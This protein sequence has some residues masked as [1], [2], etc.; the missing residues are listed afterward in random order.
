MSLNFVHDF[1][2]A[3]RKELMRLPQR[4]AKDKLQEPLLSLH[5]LTWDFFNIVILCALQILVAPGARHLVA[6]VFNFQENDRV[7]FD[8]R[9]KL[10]KSN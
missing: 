1:G 2:G 8:N 10:K 3:R 9:L 6:D 4:L 7:F 5:I